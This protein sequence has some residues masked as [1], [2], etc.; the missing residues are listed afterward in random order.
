MP[1]T[2]PRVKLAKF[3]FSLAPCRNIVQLGAFS[4]IISSMNKWKMWNIRIKK[5]TGRLQYSVMRN[6]HLT[7]PSP[8]SSCVNTL[9]FGWMCVGL[10]WLALVPR[11]LNF[12]ALKGL[13]IGRFLGPDDVKTGKDRLANL[14]SFATL[15]GLPFSHFCSDGRQLMTILESHA[16]IWGCASIRIWNSLCIKYE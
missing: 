3:R 2:Y 1:D 6:L 4:I 13:E 16:H 9:S 5:M 10:L 8:S 11:G 7:P 15:S 12:G 14:R